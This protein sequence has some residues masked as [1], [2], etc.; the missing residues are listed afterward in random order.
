MSRIVDYM[1]SLASRRD[2]VWD[3][4]SDIQREK[5]AFLFDYFN[6]DTAPTVEFDNHFSQC[7]LYTLLD[8]QIDQAM[9]VAHHNKETRLK[10]TVYGMV[11]SH[12][13]TLLQSFIG[14]SLI[15]L[16]KCHSQILQGL[17]TRYDEVNKHTKMTLSEIIKFPN[18][19]KGKIITLLQ[20]DTFHNPD[21][22]IKIFHEAIGEFGKGIDTTQ[23]RPII[24]R[25]HD[26]IHRN[27]MSPTGEK[28]VLEL[29][30]LEADI[31]TI[32]EFAG[33]LL[34]RMNSAIA[35]I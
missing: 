11:C 35:N 5:W 18:G 20:N 10:R 21:T 4:M 31:K 22:I 32:R 28:I 19:A 9:M 26:I 27:G 23:L 17:A 30:M 8:I 15:V 24:S 14:D 12:S 6:T 16:A 29:E 34:N 2:D 13:V 1:I 7:K 33:D 25:R 3:K